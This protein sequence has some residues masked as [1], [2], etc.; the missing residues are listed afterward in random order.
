MLRLLVI[1]ST[2]P[3]GECSLAFVPVK[4]NNVTVTDF[5]SRLRFDRFRATACTARVTSQH[6]RTCARDVAKRCGLTMYGPFCHARCLFA[7]AR[8][9]TCIIFAFFGLDALGFRVLGLCLH[10]SARY[11]S[12]VASCL[13]LWPSLYCD[14]LLC[15]T[16]N[17]SCHYVINRLYHSTLRAVPRCYLIGFVMI[18]GA[19]CVCLSYLTAAV[20]RFSTTNLCF[21]PELR[22]SSG[23][24]LPL[25]SA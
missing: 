14:A 1:L 20:P 7:L 9:G 22:F 2:F 15:I 13:A 16:T 6:G 12:M 10:I 17:V 23:V 11:P 5:L 19:K 8:F 24:L 4:Q 3:I 25:R 18:V 21:S